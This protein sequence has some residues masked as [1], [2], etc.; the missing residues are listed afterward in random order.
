MMVV[1]PTAALAFGL[2]QEPAGWAVDIARAYTTLACTPLTRR[3]VPLSWA[4]RS[5]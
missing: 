4:R 2:I 5:F 3:K 1:Y